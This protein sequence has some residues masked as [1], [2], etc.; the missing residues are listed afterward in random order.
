MYLGLNFNLIIYLKLLNNFLCYLEN[1]SGLAFLKIN[2][3]LNN[4]SLLIKFNFLFKLNF[5]LNKHTLTQYKTL[6]EICAS[7]FVNLQ[8]RFHLVYV[9]L[10]SFFNNRLNL[11]CNIS[12]FDQLDSLFNIFKGSIWL[13][14]EVFDMFGIFFKNN[15]DL[16]RILTD[17]GFLGFPLRKDF[18]LSGFLEVCYDENKKQVIYVPLQLSQT[19]R[20]F[21]FFKSMGFFKKL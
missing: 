6:S 5:F 20:K 15:P 14:R 9:L 8:N 16:R 2:F 18:P 10:S 12:E 19:F 17:Y 1:L 3:K 21:F 4:W 13:E 11:I 7:D